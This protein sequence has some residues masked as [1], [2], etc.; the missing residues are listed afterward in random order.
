MHDA[1]ALASLLTSKYGYPAHEVRLLRNATRIQ[2]LDGID[3]LQETS[4]PD[5]QVLIYYAGHGEYNKNEDG[6]WV[7][8]DGELR[9]RHQ[10]ISNSDVLN[11]LRAVKA[12]HKLLI[13]D[14]CFSGNLFTRGIKR[15][16][17]EQ[18]AQPAWISQPTG[19]SSTF[20]RR[21][22]TSGGDSKALSTPEA[23]NVRT[24]GPSLKCAAD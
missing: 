16:S 3:W 10:H 1:E 2:M 21:W 24:H 8:V 17:E 18:P 12:R 9:K 20:L 5:D 11:K 7:P 23:C 4:G 19:I 14:S 22:S 13:S 6:W 15:T